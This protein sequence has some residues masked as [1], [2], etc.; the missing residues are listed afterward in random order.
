MIIR[1]SSLSSYNDCPRRSAA[2]MFRKTISDAAG[3]ALNPQFSRVDAAI[4]TAVH[5]GAEFGF[6]EK[7]AGH[8][9][10][11]PD[12][13]ESAVE[14]FRKEIEQGVVYDDISPNN[15]HA[16]FQVQKMTFLFNE[17]VLPGIEPAMKPEKEFKADLGDGF[18][19]SGHP[20][21][22]SRK[23]VEDLK[24]GKGTAHHA[25]MG[26]YSLLA[27]SNHLPTTSNLIIHRIKRVPKTKPPQKPESSI[28]NAK[29]C[30]ID[31]HGTIIRIKRDITEFE[32]SGNPAVFPANPMSILCSEKYCPAHGTEFCGITK[33]I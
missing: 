20:D 12:M 18:I 27:K 15:N 7:L 8:V 19:L 29:A 21:V 22:I 32:K 33:K 14:Q 30:E 4:G 13:E 16:E 23:A 26:A 25:Q 28:Y 9:P 2:R 17:Y 11:L 31:A 24:T 6:T 1:A 10:N 3:F 5:K